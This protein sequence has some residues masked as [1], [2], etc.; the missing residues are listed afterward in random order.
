MERLLATFRAV[1]DQTED[2]AAPL[3]PEDC[4]VQ[5]MPDASPTKWHLAH[6]TWFFD[7]FLLQPFADG[8]RR[9]APEYGYLFNSYYNA[10]GPMHCRDRRGVISR[11]TLQE[12]RE[13]RRF[14]D[15]QVVRL[16]RNASPALLR[17]LLPLLELGLHHEQQH[18]ELLL[19]D[20]KHAFAQNPL[21]PVYTATPARPAL[22]V[23]P[24]RWRAHT[25]GLR[26]IG[27]G[28]D[29]GFAFDNERPR[30]R[31]FLEAFA[32]A[33]RLVTNGEYAGFIADGGYTRPEL[34]LSL[35]WATLQP[36]RWAAPLYW[37]LED[38]LWHE[39]T[40]G[41]YR[42]INDAEPVCHLSYFEAD[43]YARW[44]G[45]RLPTEAEWEVAATELPVGGNFVEQRRFHPAPAADA[46]PAG[47]EPELRQMYGDVWEWTRSPYA[48]Y[49]GYAP[50]VGALGEY[51]G[52][53]MCNQ[54][55]LRGGSC[56]SAGAHL[57]ATYRNFFAP[58]KRWQFAG[59]RLARDPT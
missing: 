36:E 32:L 4:V 40:L 56:A 14:V 25:E 51:N 42:L 3:A 12:T 30:H 9:L 17:R 15:Q 35:G 39:Y 37:R 31:V 21:H 23:A 8:F 47:G 52:K 24:L 34:W 5:S 28:T 19:T 33:D 53:F 45:A 13:Y 11:P 6:T 57:R 41:G 2:L 49:P 10:A 58:E 16:V 26:W 43:A 29:T 46:L 7:T 48:P 20:I 59:I 1:R 54:M 22:P 50:A 55:V 27:A 44:A 18:Q 38:D